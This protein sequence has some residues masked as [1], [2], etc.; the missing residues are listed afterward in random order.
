MTDAMK[1]AVAIVTGGGT[2]IGAAVV[3]RLAARGVRCVINYAS[4]RDDAEA[5]AADVEEAIAVQ[6]DIVEDAACRA[7][8]GAAIDA[9]GRIDFLVNNAGRTKFAN[10]EDLEALSAEDFI[11]I[12]RLNTIAPFQMVRACAPAM[13]TGGMGAVVNV[14]SVA[15]V[16]GNGSSVAYAASKGALVTMTQ[17]LA[18]ALAPAIR[19]NA[20]A[21]GYVGTGWFEKRLGEAGLAALNARIAS[22][23]PMA[24]AA[25]ADDIA[26]P[27]VMLLDPDN[28]VMT[29][30]TLL[31]DA[32]AHLDVGLSRR[33]GKEL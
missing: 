25:G 27:I 10:H 19:V 15:G 29:G 31:L 13:R 30:E 33:P 9:F 24:M 2:G 1:G 6:A 28:R 4:S 3:R 22:Q 21:P 32:G 8:A 14:A 5:L 16:F 23:T 11:D 12:Y 20:V 17:S 18:R 26:G 7:L